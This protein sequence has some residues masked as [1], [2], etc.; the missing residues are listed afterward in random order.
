MGK[1]LAR[2]AFAGLVALS[3][4]AHAGPFT[5]IYVFGDSLSDPGNASALTGG[6][7]PAGS[8]RFTNGPTAAEQLATRL[9]LSA[10]AQYGAS[11]GTNYAVGGAF[12]GVGNLNQGAAP[13]LATTGVQ[14]QI[15]RFDASNFSY[16]RSS[17]LFVLNGGANDLFFLLGTGGGTAGQIQSTAQQAARNIVPNPQPPGR[18]SHS[19]FCG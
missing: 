13:V 12:S 7:V 16:N 15:A 5:G 6:A 4:F 1:L 10:N 19:S 14:S 17:T 9:G 8:Q 2:A 3:G 11:S 18:W